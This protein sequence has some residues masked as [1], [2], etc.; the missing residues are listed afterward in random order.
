LELMGTKEACTKIS[1]ILLVKLWA[2]EAY[3]KSN[4]TMQ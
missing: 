4:K 1:S 2:F 3:E